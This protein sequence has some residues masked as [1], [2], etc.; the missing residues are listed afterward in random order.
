MESH[1]S[2]ERR[3]F[4]EGAFKILA[5]GNRSIGILE[6]WLGKPLGDAIPMLNFVDLDSF[7][8]RHRRPTADKRSV[9]R[10]LCVARLA[11]HEKGQDI[12][13]QSLSEILDLNWHLTFAGEGPDHRFLEGLARHLGISKRV[14][15]LG[16]VPSSNVP[17][18][19]KAHDVFV[20]SSRYEGLPLSLL[21]A[22][23]SGLPCIASDVGSIREVLL[24][25][26]TGLLVQPN[27]PIQLTEALR[28][29]IKDVKLREK[30]STA[31]RT[32]VMQKCDENKFLEY[33][34]DLLEK[35]SA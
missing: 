11:I 5:T 34:A 21:E 16:D 1:A 8:A 20:L 31:G 26:E 2:E 24:H 29:M 13:L 12:L 14:T 10:L 19:L 23:A 28:R 22:M 4:F 30:C 35:S 7:T 17:K 33:I 6:K 9:T 32:L 18:L 27:N 15:F 3:A 25:E